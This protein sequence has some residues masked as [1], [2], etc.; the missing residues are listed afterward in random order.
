MQLREQLHHGMAVLRVQIS[1]GLIRQHYRGLAHQRARN[2]HALLLSTRELRGMMPGTMT[3]VDP[4]ERLHDP[5]AAFAPTELAAEGQRQLHVLVDRQ[6]L[7]EVERLKDETDLGVAYAGALG[8]I[9][10]L[11]RLAVQRVAPGRGCIEQRQNGEERGLAASGRSFDRD[12]LS[13][14]YLEMNAGERVRFHIVCVEH[15]LHVLQPD[16]RFAGFLH[17]TAS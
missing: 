3:H 17:D 10:L 16:Q 11:H 1:R 14:P 5:L 8:V 12:E 6:V 13:L 15:L 4:L 7:D 9:E 2:G